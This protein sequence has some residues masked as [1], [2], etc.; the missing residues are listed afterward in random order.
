M[1]NV[2]SNNK[3]VWQRKH[4]TKLDFRLNY[5]QILLDLITS[6]DEI[7]NKNVMCNYFVLKTKFLWV[8]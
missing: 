7:Q 1:E 8:L 6:S 3:T 4:S 5:I 2:D